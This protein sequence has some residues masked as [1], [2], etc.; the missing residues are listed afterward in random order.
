MSKGSR[1]RKQR[2]NWINQMNKTHD[3]FTDAT[4]GFVNRA[5]E[6][7]GGQVQVIG[8]IST[9]CNF[10]KDKVKNRIGDEWL[11]S[12]K[13]SEPN[14]PKKLID[15]LMKNGWTDEDGNV[16]FHQHYQPLPVKGEDGNVYLAMNDTTMNTPAAMGY[17]MEGQRLLNE[18]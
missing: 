17:M 10:H 12:L 2:E 11:S 1:L 15:D 18:V 7:K 3:A 6:Q 16:C 5:V 4:A 14:I 9:V 8:F 13:K